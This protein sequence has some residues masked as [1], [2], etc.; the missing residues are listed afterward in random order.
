[1]VSEEVGGLFVQVDYLPKIIREEFSI[2]L[3]V[4]GRSETTIRIYCFHIEKFLESV[5]IPPRQ[6]S[7]SDIRG[8][9]SSLYEQNRYALNTI[10]VKIRALR[11]FYCFLHQTG[12]TFCNPTEDLAEPARKTRLPKH[13]LSGRD[14]ARIRADMT[15]DSLQKLRDRA[16]IEVLYATGLRLSELAGLDITDLDFSSGLVHVRNG[17][18]GRDRQAVLSKSAISVLKTYLDKRL[19][20]PGDPAALWINQSGQ[21]LSGYWIWKMVRQAARNAE[22]K[23]P[24]HPHAWRHG[25]A[26]ELI[27]SG[28]SLMA[29]QRFLG[30][31]SLNTTLI[32]THLTILDLKKAHQRTHPRERDAHLKPPR[33]PFSLNCP[34]QTV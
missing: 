3:R 24:A 14:M 8:Y 4:K 11:V 25:L 33:P 10:R 9:I 29:V 28:A 34:A 15:G 31:R 23:A 5:R 30:H 27:R 26:T 6:V 19:E 32:Y 7:E 1:M 20:S 21:R 16:I 12:R 2:N 13:V 17:K 18:G 22:V